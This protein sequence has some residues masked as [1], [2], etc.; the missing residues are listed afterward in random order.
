MLLAGKYQSLVQHVFWQLANTTP[1]YPASRCFLWA[2]L[3]P[4]DAPSC[5]HVFHGYGGNRS[6]WWSRGQAGSRVSR[7]C[8]LERLSAQLS[9]CG[10]GQAGGGQAVVQPSNFHSSGLGGWWILPGRLCDWELSR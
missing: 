3:P 10:G 9:R 8:R 4:A 7:T 5:Q 6:S 2:K 1:G